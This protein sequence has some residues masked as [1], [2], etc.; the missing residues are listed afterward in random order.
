MSRIKTF[1]FKMQ[2]GKSANRN[3]GRLPFVYSVRAIQDPLC[4]APLFATGPSREAVS[5]LMTKAVGVA[6]SGVFSQSLC[7]MRHVPGELPARGTVP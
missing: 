3:R 5:R 7:L 2:T 6:R 1:V 4:E